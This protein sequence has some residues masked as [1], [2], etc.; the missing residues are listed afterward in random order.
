MG[1][2]R[3]LSLAREPDTPHHVVADVG[4]DVR[5]IYFGHVRD[6]RH[7]L[8]FELITEALVS[9]LHGIRFRLCGNADP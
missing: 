5:L 1:G 9:D 2:E 3:T 7:T 4:R 8:D 6:H